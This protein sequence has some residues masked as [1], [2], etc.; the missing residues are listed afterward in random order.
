LS[1]VGAISAENTFKEMMRGKLKYCLLFFCLFS[2]LAAQTGADCFDPIRIAD[3]TN[4]CSAN[5][6]YST[7]GLGL[8]GYEPADCFN[9]EQ[10]DIW[11]VFTAEATEMS[12]I[13]RGATRSARGGSLQAP[14]AQLYFGNCGQTLSSG[15]NCASDDPRNQFVELKQ[16]GLLPGQ[17]Y[18]IRVQSGNGFDGS[19]QLCI[20]NFNAPVDPQSDCPQGALLC[21]KSSFIVPLIDGEGNDPDELMDALCF[22]NGFPGANNETNS[23]WFKWICKESGSLTFALS[24]LNIVDDLDFVLFELPNGID[25][26]SDNRILRCMAAGAA[27]AEYPTDC[28]GPTGLR[29]EANDDSEPA[30][31]E[32]GQDNWLRPINME[33]GKAYAL[34]VNNFSGSGSGFEIEFGGT[35]TFE[36]TNT[37]F[38]LI[39]PEACYEDPLGIELIDSSSVDS[40]V[41]VNW[42]F[43]ASANPGTGTGE[44]PFSITYDKAGPKV[45]S[46]EVLSSK[47][48]KETVTKRFELICCDPNIFAEAGP[49]QTVD[50]GEQILISGDAFLP[51]GNIIAQWEPAETIDC[52]TCFAT[53]ALP[54]ASTYY[55]FSVSDSLGCTAIDS[56]Y[57]DLK[58]TYPAYIPNSFSPNGDNINDFFT[59]YSN[60]SASGMDLKVFSRWGEL[61]YEAQNIMP[62]IESSGWDGTFKG[63]LADPGIYVYLLEIRFIDGSVRTFEGDLWLRR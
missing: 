2:S 37:D 16:D 4:F 7:D 19:F 31:C 41:Q 33:A 9:G 45:I 62:G 61:V 25:D 29:P 58:A 48:C 59:A 60:V 47:G 38:E 56:F 43:G 10:E 52:P 27:I 6:A 26:C 11:F 20:R 13:V 5:E 49:D 34:A 15:V 30:G 28:H 8:S 57:L 22:S 54:I 14:E 44:G 35:G 53:T 32:Q 50:L 23:T 24:P 12:V 1:L 36:G 55:F 46:M 3:P 21:D 18:F 51:G 40:V 17:D 42:Y 39:S 63:R